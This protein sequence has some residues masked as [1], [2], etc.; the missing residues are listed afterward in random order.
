MTKGQKQPRRKF[1]SSSSS[2]S[3]S[4]DVIGSPPTPQPR[5]VYTPNGDQ[6]LELIIETLMGTSFEV[7]IPAKTLV[8]SIKNRLQKSE[9]VPRH[10]LHIIHGGNFQLLSYFDFIQSQTISF[11][12][13]CE[14]WEP[15]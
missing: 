9:G 10:H 15:L 3:S 2:S 7:R 5:V 13:K 14:S 11:F 12:Q 8:A 4:D 6:V 1:L